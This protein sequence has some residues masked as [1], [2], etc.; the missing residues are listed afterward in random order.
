MLPGFLLIR[1]LTSGLVAVPF[2]ANSAAVAS[3]QDEEDFVG[4]S[5]DGLAGLWNGDET[6]RSIVL[7]SGSLLQWPD[8]KK[9]GVINFAT[10]AQNAVVLEHL[11]R[12][13]C[14]QVPEPRTISIDHAR[15]QAWWILKCSRF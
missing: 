12:I 11:I 7:H 2:M 5:L 15:E 9:T 1:G 8:P 14:P 13:W 4:L 3:D 10:M 6:I